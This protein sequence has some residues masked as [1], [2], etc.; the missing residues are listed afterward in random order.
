MDTGMLWFDNE[1][2]PLAEKIT[3]AAAYYR[4]KYGE[5]PNCCHVPLNGNTP[6]PVDGIVVIPSAYIQ[7]NY[8]WIG[9]EQDITS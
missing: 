9:L 4:S 7:P 5:I 1:K 8:L 6:A 2:K 3:E